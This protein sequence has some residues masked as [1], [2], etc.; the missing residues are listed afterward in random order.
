[1]VLRYDCDGMEPVALNED[2][3]ITYQLVYYRD[4]FI[5]TPTSGP[6]CIEGCSY[7]YLRD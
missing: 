6:V 4:Y 2:G 3:A 1:M 5:V 7:K